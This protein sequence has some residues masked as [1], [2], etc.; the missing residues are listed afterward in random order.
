[1]AGERERKEE[2]RKKERKREKERK[3]GERRGRET[4]GGGENIRKMWHAKWKVCTTMRVPSISDSATEHVSKV[5]LKGIQ[6]Y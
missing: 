4:R 3:R 1:M 5:R 6:R 2:R